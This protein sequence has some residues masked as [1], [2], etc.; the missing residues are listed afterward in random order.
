MVEI[1]FRVSTSSNLPYTLIEFELKEPIEPSDLIK[2][3][4]KL[5]RIDSTKGVVISGRGPIWLHSF[6]AH[7]YHPTKFVAHYDPRLGGAVVVQSHN[8]KY[9][10]GQIIKLEAEK[11]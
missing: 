7:F 3:Y 6:L 8:R 4:T 9:H 11:E 5:P 10:V 1:E 2:L